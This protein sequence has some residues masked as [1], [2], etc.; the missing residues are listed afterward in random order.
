ML[1]ALLILKSILWAASA[2]GA[3][4]PAYRSCEPPA[5]K[6]DVPVKKACICGDECKCKTGDCPNK[7]PVAK[8]APAPAPAPAVVVGPVLSHYELRE[9]TQCQ[10]GRCVRVQQWVPVYK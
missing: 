1:R 7:C 5:Y 9:T 4:P 3:E 8:P 6:P 10:G 2:F